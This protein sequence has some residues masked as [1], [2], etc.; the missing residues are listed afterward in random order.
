MVMAAQIEA[1]MARLG[2]AATLR[3]AGHA[4]RVRP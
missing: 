4:Q 3:P 1:A 2:Y